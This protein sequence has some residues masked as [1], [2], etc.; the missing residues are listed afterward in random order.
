MLEQFSESTQI[1]ASSHSPLVLKYLKESSW[2]GV[3][4]FKRDEK[5][6]HTIV[7]KL[8]DLPRLQEAIRHDNL[9]FLMATGWMEEAMS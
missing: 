8:T 6:G 4:I 1:I 5:T 3:L 9:E 7:R 2:P